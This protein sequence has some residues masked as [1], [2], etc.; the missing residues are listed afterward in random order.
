MDKFYKAI[1]IVIG[2]IVLTFLI[3]CV[4]GTILYFIWPITIPK[5]FPGIVENGYLAAEL[6]WWQSVC[7]TWVFSILIK[8]T[9]NNNNN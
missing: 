6:T 1:G 4:S 3:A 7:L 2:V 8:S 5:V 9:T